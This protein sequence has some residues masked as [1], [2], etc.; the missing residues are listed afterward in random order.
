[1]TSLFLLVIIE[2]SDMFGLIGPVFNPTQKCF[3]KNIKLSCKFRSS[4]LYSDIREECEKMTHTSFEQDK[5]YLK[6]HLGA[7]LNSA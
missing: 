7:E 1:M 4:C 2:R 5:D 3:F 6:E